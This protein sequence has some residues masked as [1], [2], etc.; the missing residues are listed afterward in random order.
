MTMTSAAHHPG[1]I[2][3]W[4][5]AA[6]PKTLPAGIVPV[7]VGGVLAFN[8]GFFHLPSFLAALFGA[9]L[10]Q[11]G[12]NF[13]N[14]LFDYR[15]D[16]DRSD[17]IGPLRVTQ[18]GLVTE[19]QITIATVVTFGLAFCLGIYLVYRGG[20][21]IVIIGLTSLLCG[22]IYT[23]GPF[24][25]GYHGLGELF[26][27]IFFGPVALGGTYYVQAQHITPAVILAGVPFGLISTAILVVNN[28]RDIES[29]RKSGKRTLAVRFGRTFARWEYLSAILLAALF[30]LVF[31]VWFNRHP[32]LTGVL[33][34]L[35]LAAP[36]IRR[37]F[38]TTD[39][40]AL[41]QTLAQTG[42]LLFAYGVLFSIGW[43]L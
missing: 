41:N 40:N 16:T 23:G 11:I 18:A 33:A 43:L 25:L 15:K 28:L 42:G 4:L 21:P 13:V 35:I 32:A 7:L 24:P 20:W 14:D 9:A 19:G 1:R 8:A 27:L 12:T 31:V 5:W 29:D 2:T 26:V 38:I 34:I 6:R 37:V 3:V 17:R 39:G 36:S 10:I 22:I 30:A